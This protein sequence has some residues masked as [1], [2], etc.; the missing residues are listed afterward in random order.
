MYITRALTLTLATTSLVACT[1][2]SDPSLSPRK[3]LEQALSH[4]SK[5]EYN[6]Q[7]NIKIEDLV[8]KKRRYDDHA[9]EAESVTSS[10][11]LKALASATAKQEPKPTDTELMK[12][13]A[14][15]YGARNV[16]LNVDGA[17][18]PATK[19]SE[20]NTQFGYKGHNAGVYFNLGMMSD[21]AA[22]VM[23][24]DSN[25]LYDLMIVFGL[26][27]KNYPLGDT[28]ALVKLD[29]QP[30]YDLIQKEAQSKAP[31]DL[32]NANWDQIRQSFSKALKKSY[33][34]IDDSAF[35]DQ[36][37]SS[38]DQGFHASRK[39]RLSLNQKQLTQLYKSF[40]A[41]ME[42]W[43]K[44]S[45]AKQ[46]AKVE[47]EAPHELNNYTSK[48]PS[49]QN[50]LNIDFYLG[51]NQR[52]LGSRVD[53]LI[54]DSDFKAHVS[55]NIHFNHFGAANFVIRPETRKIVDITEPL[56]AQMKKLWGKP[57]ETSNQAA[58]DAVRAAADAAKSANHDRSHIK[59]RR[60]K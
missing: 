29:M 45:V 47:A 31:E 36:P 41:E 24:M 20:F 55:G 40:E 38:E 59:H 21:D 44:N 1:S 2:I 23:Y 50:T 19:K 56:T 4:H 16:Y 58:A 26:N 48:S 18:N 15:R 27:Y 28:N 57:V 5:S 6:F 53:W 10:D 8:T 34:D 3:A 49:V 35:S 13:A 60:K 22:K 33:L 39:V 17:N 11:T 54:D 42:K 37:L 46:A 25:D 9:Y 12:Q 52:W 51:G 30:V 32:N 7:G 14:V 43:D